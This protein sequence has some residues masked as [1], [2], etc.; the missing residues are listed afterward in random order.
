MIACFFDEPESPLL[1]KNHRIPVKKSVHALSLIAR[2]FDFE[3]DA[4][5]PGRTGD[6]AGPSARRAKVFVGEIGAE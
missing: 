4:K 6:C 2:K 1:S 3:F 5:L